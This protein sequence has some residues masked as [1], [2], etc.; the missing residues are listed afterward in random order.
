M[1]ISGASIAGP[2]LAYWLDRYG[3]DVTVVE[4]SAGVR[5][6]G[7]PIDVRG[8]A[9]EVCARMGILPALREAAVN[10]RRLTALHP[11]GRVA[12]RVEVERLLGTGQTQRDVELPRGELSDLLYALTKDRVEYVF[13]DS[14]RTITQHGDTVGVTFE[15]GAPRTV[16]VVVGCDGLHSR[17]RSLAFGPEP[18]YHRYLGFCFA[19]FS[20]P[21]TAGLYREAVLQN[22]PGLGAT[23]YAIRDQPRLFTLMVFTGPQPP[24]GWTADDVRRRVRE[25]F[26]GFGGEVP[27]LLDAM[28]AA[29]DLYFDTVSQIRMPSWS[30]GRVVLAGDAGYAPSFLSGQGTSLALTGAYVLAGELHRA[31]EHAFSRYEAAMREYVRRNQDMAVGA[32]FLFPRTRPG[33]WLRNQGL[34][35]APLLSRLSSRIDRNATALTV[36]DYQAPTAA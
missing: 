7:Y 31:P 13:G 14:I 18:D 16:D 32:S 2:A 19:G 10:T 1:L 15:Q 21:N 27:R 9:I 4:R 25:R 24:R 26:A 35:A 36:E 12:G 33:L 22:G 8:S 3:F 11:D 5:Q 23:M 6:G 34:R 30:A 28:D 17:T 20:V 29:D